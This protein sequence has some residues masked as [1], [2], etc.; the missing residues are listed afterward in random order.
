MI[1]NRGDLLMN[2]AVLPLGNCNNANEGAS[3]LTDG[4][5]LKRSGNKNIGNNYTSSNSNNN[6]NN[7]NNINFNN[8]NENTLW[9]TVH[10]MQ[11]SS[12][13][14][15]PVLRNINNDMTKGISRKVHQCKSK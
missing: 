11:A 14:A 5:S 4:S 6:I 9:P 10:D 3:I 8:I 2:S 12:A 7:N 15:N 1:T 13:N